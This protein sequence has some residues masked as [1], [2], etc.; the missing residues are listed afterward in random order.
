MMNAHTPKRWL[1]LLA[2]AIAVAAGL[3]TVS[4]QHQAVEEFTAAA[5]NTNRP[6]D[7][8]RQRPT[9]AQLIIRIERWS[10]DQERDDLLAILKE[11]RDVNRANQHLL[12]AL[13]RLP[14]AGFI[15][16]SSSLRWDLRFARQA[17]LEDGGRRIVVASD[18]PMPF[19]EVRDRPR[20]FDYPFTVFELR[21]DKNNRG[22]GK[23][24]ADTRIFIDPRT[25]DLV[26]ENYDIQPVRLT[27]IRQR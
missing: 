13:Q 7:P 16:E 27:Q 2:A 10:T 14:S 19:W 8:R 22:E 11:E 6:N 24:L 3:P 9:T 26:L 12:R 25:N 4:A 5:I 1:T 23:L 20:S 17:A 18:R 15:R 21:L